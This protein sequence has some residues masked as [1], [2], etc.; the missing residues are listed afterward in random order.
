MRIQ[1]VQREGLPAY[2]HTQKHTHTHIH[3]RIHLH[4]HAPKSGMPQ[5]VLRTT[6]V[7]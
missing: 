2:I 4:T 1:K 5:A 6:H 3:I 7:C